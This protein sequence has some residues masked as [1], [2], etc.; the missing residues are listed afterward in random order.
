MCIQ[1]EHSLCNG[2][3]FDDSELTRI[4]DCQCHDSMYQLTQRM[5]A[6]K[7]Q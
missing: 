3:I 7:N 6:A 1:N 2:E 4:C 5:Q